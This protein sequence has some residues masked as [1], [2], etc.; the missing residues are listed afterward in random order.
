VVMYETITNQSNVP[1][2]V[3]I[4]S[5][6]LSLQGRFMSGVWTQHNPHN[7]RVLSGTISSGIFEATKLEDGKRSKAR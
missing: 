4:C 1:I 2:A 7:T 5:G 3:N 6:V